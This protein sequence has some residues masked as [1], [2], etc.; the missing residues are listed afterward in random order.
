M[1]LKVGGPNWNPANSQVCYDFQ[2]H[3][4]LVQTSL[5]SPSREQSCATHDCGFRAIR[6]CGY[7]PL[8]ACFGDHCEDTSAAVVREYF[9]T[10]ISVFCCIFSHITLLVGW[11]YLLVCLCVVPSAT[12]QTLY[13]CSPTSSRSLN[14]KTFWCFGKYFSFSPT[15]PWNGQKLLVPTD[16]E[17][18]P[19]DQKNHPF[20]TSLHCVG[21]ILVKWFSQ[22]SK[23]LTCND[24]VALYAHFM[25]RSNY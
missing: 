17:Q 9:T 11:R 21:L 18:I 12:V 1:L 4:C 14:E 19:P 20:S 7:L 6:G 13:C 8:V 3:A 2:W 10:V 25:F 22:S 15:L 5:M 24:H 16:Q 23:S